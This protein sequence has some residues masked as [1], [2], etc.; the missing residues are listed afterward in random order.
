MPPAHVFVDPPGFGEWSRQDQ[1][2][3]RLLELRAVALRLGHQ[4]LV[5][6]L[7]EPW[8]DHAGPTGFP[9]NPT[10]C[11]STG[12][13]PAAGLAAAAGPA[14]AAGR[15]IGRRRVVILEGAVFRPVDR[16]AIG[17]L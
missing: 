15:R 5:K 10:G 6:N 16:H 4:E 17:I 12:E 9:P 2:A 8:M 1:V 11:P 3:H 13:E 14:A 7:V